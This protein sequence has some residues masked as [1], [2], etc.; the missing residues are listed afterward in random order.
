MF[1]DERSEPRLVLNSNAF[2]PSVLFGDGELHPLRYCRKPILLR[3]SNDTLGV[4]IP[5]FQ[6]AKN[7]GGGEVVNN[8]LILLWCREKRIITGAIFLVV[9]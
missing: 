9:Y 1:V 8:D 5:S 4:A 2:L 7:R 3:N 6:A